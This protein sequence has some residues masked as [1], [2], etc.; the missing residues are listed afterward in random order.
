MSEAME[1]RSR[2]HSI[3]KETGWV[4]VEEKEHG[5]G[6]WMVVQ[7]FAVPEIVDVYAKLAEAEQIV[8]GLTHAAEGRTAGMARDY[9]LNRARDF[10][11]QLE[12]RGVEK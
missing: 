7:T 3:D 6:G 8:R 10:L 12:A 1:G 5:E 2:R 4:T 9:C 11:T